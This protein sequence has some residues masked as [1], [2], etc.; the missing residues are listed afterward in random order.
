MYA[1]EKL[2]VVEVGADQKDHL[3]GWLSKR[4]G[5]TLVA[6]DFTAEGF[7]LVGGRLLPLA[8]RPAAQFMYQDQSGNR[9]SLY[10]TGD[11]RWRGN[12]LP[13]LRAKT[14]RWRSTGSTRAIATP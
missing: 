3:V 9:V 14:A 1:A 2:H 11:E 4:V 6:A 10:V 7:E 8:E 12:R 13:P 5:T